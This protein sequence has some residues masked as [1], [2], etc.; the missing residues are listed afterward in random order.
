MTQANRGLEG[1]VA[2]LIDMSAMQRQDIAEMRQIMNDG[3]AKLTEAQNNLTAKVDKLAD[4][5]DSLAMVTQA[6]QVV[7]QSQN[8]NIAA[9]IAH[10]N[11]LLANKA[12]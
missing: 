10:A 6:Q 4:K 3:F 5:I 9:L 12:G 11:A 1:V 7:S 8:E 2:N